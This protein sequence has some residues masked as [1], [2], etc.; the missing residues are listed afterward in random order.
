MKP[1]RKPARCHICNAPVK[2]R[3]GVRYDFCDEHKKVQRQIIHMP[4]VKRP[5]RPRVHHKKV[6]TRYMARYNEEKDRWEVYDT[7]S[8]EV[9]TSYNNKRIALRVATQLNNKEPIKK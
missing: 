6:T 9:Y 5:G 4:A 8:R 3:S 7:R 1:P 2:R